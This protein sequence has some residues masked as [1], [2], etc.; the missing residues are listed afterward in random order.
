M[1]RRCLK[2]HTRLAPALVIMAMVRSTEELAA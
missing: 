2:E 1:K